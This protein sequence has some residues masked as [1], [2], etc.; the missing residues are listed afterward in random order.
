M[1]CIILFYSSQVTLGVQNVNPGT[2]HGSI[3][4]MDELHKLVPETEE[5]LFPILAHG[6]GKR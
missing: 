2:T 6:D 1:I 4:V 5:G 3:V